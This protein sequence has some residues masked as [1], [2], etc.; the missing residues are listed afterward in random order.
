[1]S[2]RIKNLI[3]ATTGIDLDPGSISDDVNTQYAITSLLAVAANSDGSVDSRET[4]RMIEVLMQRFDLSA[5]NALDFV[6]RAL[7]DLAAQQSSAALI[8]DLNRTLSLRQKEDC[9]VM[10]LEVIAA[11]GEKQ[12][13]EMKLLN[14]TLEALD[15]PDK[16]VAGIFQKYYA[17]REGRRQPKDS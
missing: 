3:Y 9:I 13:R 11:D 14:Q 6:T 8:H 12:A 15:I 1:M 5:I 7:D 16:M 17:G 10:L 2:N 4:S